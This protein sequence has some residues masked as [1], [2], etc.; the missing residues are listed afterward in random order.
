MPKEAQGPI[1]FLG[2][3]LVVP[4][5]FEFGDTDKLSLRICSQNAVDLIYDLLWGILKRTSLT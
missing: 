4:L 5:T 3:G 2:I 1:N